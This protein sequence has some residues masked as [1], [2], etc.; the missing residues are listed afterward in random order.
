MK[1]GNQWG[2]KETYF[3]SPEKLHEIWNKSIL[4][5]YDGM[6]CLTN[7]VLFLFE[8]PRNFVRKTPFLFDGSVLCSIVTPICGELKLNRIVLQISICKLLRRFGN[9]FARGSIKL[10]LWSPI[11]LSILSDCTPFFFSKPLFL[12]DIRRI[13]AASVVRSSYYLSVA[14]QP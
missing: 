4:K 14:V 1:F 5:R 6:L 10:L 2:R 12:V 3:C 9:T 13:S 11:V 8:K 7:F